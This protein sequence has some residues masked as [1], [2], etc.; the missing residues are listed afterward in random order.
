MIYMFK[1]KKELMRY[2]CIALSS[3]KTL[4]ASHEP[5]KFI[6][7]SWHS[8]LHCIGQ[9]EMNIILSPNLDIC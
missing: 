7:N 2:S 3:G 8:P 4:E 9:R 6:S 5:P 1:N